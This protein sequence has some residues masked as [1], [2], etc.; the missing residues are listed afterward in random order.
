[1]H[2]QHVTQIEEFA[3]PESWQRMKRGNLKR[4]AESLLAA[5]QDQILRTNYRKAELE[6]Q[7]VSPLCRMCQK[8]DET[9]THL[10]CEC[11]KRAQIQYKVRIHRM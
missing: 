2:V 10:V 6:K 3:G 8:K 5:A 9:I 4:E 1:M 7:P 11:S